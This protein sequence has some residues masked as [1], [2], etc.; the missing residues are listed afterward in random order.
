[1]TC[2]L[3]FLILILLAVCLPAVSNQCG[4]LPLVLADIII[5]IINIM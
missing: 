3:L 5:I 2:Q 4:E 1:M